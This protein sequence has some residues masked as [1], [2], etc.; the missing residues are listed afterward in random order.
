MNIVIGGDFNS[1]QRR[2]PNGAQQVLANPGLIDGYAAPEKVNGN[3]STVNYTPE[4]AQ[5]QG[6]PAPAVLLRPGH[7][8]DR[9]HLLHRGPR[10]ATR[11]SCT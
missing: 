9:L 5:V 10:N 7:D 1:Y 4:D 6:L 3:Y 8:P 11:S 2:Q